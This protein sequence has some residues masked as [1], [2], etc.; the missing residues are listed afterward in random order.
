MKKSRRI[1][2]NGSL[3]A[4]IDKRAKVNAGGDINIRQGKINVFANG[5]FNQRKSISYNSTDRYNLFGEPL[6]NVFQ[7]DTP[8]NNNQF[9]SGSAGI[10]YFI[11]NRN[12]ITA[13][14]SYTQGK[15][16]SLDDI[17][18]ITDT[19]LDFGTSSSNAIR[20]TNNERSF[21][22]VGGALLFKHLFP[23]EDKILT[24]DIHY[25]QN[26]IK[27]NG[28]FITHYFDD[29]QLP[30]GFVT[31]QKQEGSGKNKFITGQV[32]FEDPVNDKLKLQTG[33]RAAIRSFT[34]E[35]H[36]FAFIDST[37][38]YSEIPDLN[39]YKFDDQVYAAYGTISSRYKELQYQLGLRIESSFYEGTLT[40]VNQ[41]F[42]NNFPLSIFPS[43]FLSY[44]INK[45]SDIQVNY[46]RRI[47]R[48]SFF[49]LMPFTDYTDSL[50]LQSGNPNLLPQFTN[51]IEL[52]YQKNFNRA[53]NLLASVYYKNT[54]NLITRFQQLQ[55]DSLLMNDVIINTYENANSSYLAGV[56]L[57]ASNSLTKWFNLSTNLNFYQSYIDG[58]N[59]KGNL[60]NEQFSWFAK[61]NATFKI[62]L[63]FSLQLSGDYQSRTSVPQGGSSGFGGGGGRGMGGGFFGIPPATV[64]GYLNPVY[65]LDVSVKK[66]FLKNKAA[67]ITLSFSDLL[68]TRNY[69]THY[70]TDFFI[71]NSVRVRDPQFI[72][73][74]FSYRFGKYD[75]SLFKR[76]NIPNN[77]EMIQDMQ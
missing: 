3:R 73:L 32:D 51:T 69:T 64:Q 66:E 5:N 54:T 20:N 57:T 6:T 37:N 74:N 19:I 22:N 4:G 45:T 33:A 48:P 36:V 61:V 41:S 53:N 76:K 13:S 56:E 11:N 8:I 14:G 52:T 72:R 65:E 10:D 25:N 43:G 46:T 49:Q 18:L 71:Q 55:F 12:T 39:N 26:T 40:D 59:I 63:N 1:G 42:R 31:E 70:E 34:S 23:K 17:F 7:T 30:N 67:A 68:A 50:N 44:P 62:P 16:N 75:A 77:G 29:H 28:L 27:N 47:D 35:N 2:Y 60:T 9:A 15:F 24:A 38:V 58:S 21:N